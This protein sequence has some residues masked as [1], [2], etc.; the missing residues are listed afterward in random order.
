ML[1]DDLKIRLITRGRWPFSIP[2][3]LSIQQCNS[4]T[5]HPHSIP[6]H[7]ITIHAHKPSAWYSVL[8]LPYPLPWRYPASIH[9]TDPAFEYL[10][11]HLRTSR[12]SPSS[13]NI[14]LIRRRGDLQLL[15]NDV[16]YERRWLWKDDR[17]WRILDTRWRGTPVTSIRLR[18]IEFRVFVCV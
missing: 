6:I 10:Q 8:N 14:L 12:R 18:C 1:V 3:G 15:L 16:D 13:S 2:H 4:I 7:T 5:L 17:G 11:V 9:P